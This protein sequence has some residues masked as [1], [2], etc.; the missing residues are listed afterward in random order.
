VDR[1]P[2]PDEFAERVRRYFEQLGQ[3]P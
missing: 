3:G 1:D 2:V